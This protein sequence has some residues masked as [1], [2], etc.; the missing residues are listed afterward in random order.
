ML[1]IHFVSLHIFSNRRI[2]ENIQQFSACRGLELVFLHVLFG[3][4]PVVTVALPGLCIKPEQCHTVQFLAQNFSYSEMK[5][6]K[7]SS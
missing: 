5:S 6:R 2:K 7:I 3:S 4:R 1:G